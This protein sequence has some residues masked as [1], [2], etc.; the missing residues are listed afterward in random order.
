[1]LLTKHWCTQPQGAT[2]QFVQM[3][4]AGFCPP[5]KVEDSPA[6]KLRDLRENILG[7]DIL[8]L[9]SPCKA[10][11]SAVI[12]KLPPYREPEIFIQIFLPQTG[13]NAKV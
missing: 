9:P 13:L 3:N 8:E 4:P 12:H 11:G 1:M 2:N 10:D 5:G 7:A 6:G